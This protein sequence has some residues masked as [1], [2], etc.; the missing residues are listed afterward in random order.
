MKYLYTLVS[1]AI[2]FYSCSGQVEPT[3]VEGEKAYFG[4]EITPTNPMTV[5]EL[6]TKM[7]SSDSLLNVS[8][9]GEIIETCAMKGCWMTIANGDEEPMRV[10]FKDYG[11]FVPTE[12]A[13][14]KETVF[15]GE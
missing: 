15:T 2:L 1:V 3:K 8:V 7:M 12:G 6:Q 10:R 4:E 9:K 14:G 11:F 5:A 13:G